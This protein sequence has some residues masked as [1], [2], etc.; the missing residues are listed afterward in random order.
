MTEQDQEYDDEDEG[1]QE[2]FAYADYT[3]VVVMI[4]TYYYRTLEMFRKYYLLRL[5]GKDVKPLKQEIQSYISTTV[6]LLRNYEPI[7]NKKELNNLFKKIIE[8]TGTLNTLS[9]KKM[10]ECI[11]CLVDA[12]YVLGLSKLEFIKKDP[13]AAVKGR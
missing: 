11:N 6:Q 9:F 13:S 12:H 3:G 5:K 1:R 4:Q 2:T 8:F 7:K 10:S